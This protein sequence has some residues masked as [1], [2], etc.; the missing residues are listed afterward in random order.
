MNVEKLDKKSVDIFGTTYTINIVDTLDKAE[1]ECSYYGE[2]EYSSKTIKI[3]R[4]VHN[5][6]QSDTEMRLTLLHELIHAILSTGQYNNSSNDEPLV[7]WLTRC[8]YS[9]KKQNIL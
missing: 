5:I 8:I 3:G 9:L 4:N 6:K 7:E 2:T 1:D